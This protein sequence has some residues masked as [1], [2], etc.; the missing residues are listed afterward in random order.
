MTPRCHLLIL[1]RVLDVVLLTALASQVDPTM[2][3]SE[4]IDLDDALQT[5]C[6]RKD[7]DD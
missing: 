1:L 4:K 2:D 5:V 7:I 3:F 6:V